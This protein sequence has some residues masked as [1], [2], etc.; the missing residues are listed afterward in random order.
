MKPKTTESVGCQDDYFVSILMLDIK[1]YK[2]L[3]KLPFI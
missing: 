1:D 2:L 3:L